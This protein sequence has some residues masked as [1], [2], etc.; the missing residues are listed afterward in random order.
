MYTNQ[1]RVENYL[2]RELTS[3]EIELLDETIDYISKFIESFTNRSWLPLSDEEDDSEEIEATGR[4]FDGNG[5][6]ELFVDDFTELES[7]RL[8]DSQGN[9]VATYSDETNWSLYPLNSDVRQSIRLRTSPFG[10]G[11]GSVSIT[12]VWGSGEVPTSVIMVCT[13]LV[14]NFISGMGDSSGQY[15]KES[16]EGYSYELLDGTVSDEQTQSLLNTLG[17]YKKFTL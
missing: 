5:S 17:R 6:Y 14:G 2:K 10:N 16:I 4:I 15:K 11:S 8:L 12:A 3:A 1:S 13:A 9:I 7:I